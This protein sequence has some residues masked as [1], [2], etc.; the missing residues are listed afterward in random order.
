MQACRNGGPCTRIMPWANAVPACAR[1]SA[2]IATRMSGRRRIEQAD[3]ELLRTLCRQVG[4]RRRERHMLLFHR[5]TQ[6]APLAPQHL[7]LSII[8]PEDGGATGHVGAP[9]GTHA[10]SAQPVGI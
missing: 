10:R 8:R 9:Q 5:L 3:P 6:I 7:V 4:P 1:K 2:R